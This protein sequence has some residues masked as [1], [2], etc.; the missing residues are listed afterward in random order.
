[1]ISHL[2]SDDRLALQSCLCHARA[3]CNHACAMPAGCEPARPHFPAAVHREHCGGWR[4]MQKCFLRSLFATRGCHTEALLHGCWQGACL[5]VSMAPSKEKG[6]LGPEYGAC[7]AAAGVPTTW[8]RAHI[9]LPHAADCTH[10]HPMRTLQVS[11][12]TALEAAAKYPPLVVGASAL[13]FGVA[14][15]CIGWH[16]WG[17]SEHAVHALPMLWWWGWGFRSSRLMSWSC[18][19]WRWRG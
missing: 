6:G 17:C 12:V 19:I 5:P 7:L 10:A 13:F 16:G 15:E 3:L 1:M 4:C 11:T 8:V 14:C 2:C 18:F 9:C